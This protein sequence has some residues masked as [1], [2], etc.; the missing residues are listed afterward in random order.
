MSIIVCLFVAV[1]SAR[2][3]DK[4]AVR[5]IQEYFANYNPETL[6]LK[7][8][9]LE[10]KRGNIVI[11]R[12][13]ITIYTNKNFGSQVFTPELVDNIYSGLKEALPSS[14]KKYN[15][16]IIANHRR[17]EYLVPNIY[18]KKKAVD[19]TRLWN[20][21]DYAGHAWVRNVSRPYAIA[22]GLDGR[23]IALW[24]SHGRVYS[25]DKNLWQWQRP[26]LFCTTEDLFT[27]SI[28]VPF[29]MPMLE[30]AG[31][32][33]YTPR[34]RSWQRHSVVVDNDATTGSSQYVEE[35]EGN[36]AW[37][38]SQYAGFAPRDTFYV[39]G[40]NPFSEGTVRVTACVSA[41]KGATA[42]AKWL[43]DI[44]EDG[45]YGVYV[46]YQTL[47][48]S[49]PD[50]R[51][52]VLHSGG[53]TNFHVNQ[54]MGGGTWVYLGSFYFK[55]GIHENQSVVLSNE[56]AYGGVVTADAVR[57]GGGMGIVARGDSLKV[58]NLPR[59]LE[60]AR[61][62]LQYSGFPYKVY[63]PS[64]GERDYNDD[65][66]SR[67]RAVN[68][69]VG[70]S[71]YCPDSAGLRVPIEMTFGFHSDA[72]I[73]EED[74]VIGSLGVVTTDY[75]D[76]TLPTGVSRYISRDFI[77]Y[78]LNCVQRDI[79]E[80]YGFR[81]SCRGIL[82]KSYSESRIPYVP[83]MIFESLS[84]QNFIDMAYGHDPNFKFVIARA[85][86]KALLKHLAYVHGRDYIVQPLPVKDFSIDFGDE[87]NTLRLAWMPVEDPLEPTAVAKKYILYTK[88][89]DNEYDNGRVVES[90]AIVFPVLPDVQ[91][92]FKVA[93]LNEGGESFPSEELS[94]CISKVEKGRVVVVNGFHRLSGPAVVNSNSLAGFD[95]DADPG[96]PYMRTP[97]YCGRQLD[98]ERI[99]T[100]FEDGLGLSGCELEG[101][102]VAGNT[103]N[104][105][106]IHGKAL[107]ANEYSY[108]SC[109]SEAVMNDYV[110]LGKYDAVDLILGCEKQGGKGSVLGYNR[111]YKTFPAELQNKITSYC[112][113]GGRIFVSGAYIASDMARN[114]SDRAFIRNILKFD[115]GGYVADMSENSIFGSNLTFEVN[116]GISEKC[117]AVTRPDI[118]APVGNSFV[119]FVFDKC[120]ESAGVAF[121]DN[122]RVLTTSFPF[123]TILQDNFRAEIMGA[124]MR[125]LMN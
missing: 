119:A 96:V 99:N 6:R 11:G 30:N 3:D 59:F 4:Q 123:E 90:N 35:H 114:D 36:A 68:H 82:D 105:P 15:I 73:S 93:A 106:Y 91:Y 31:A 17:I 115:Y 85:V 56:S 45:E 121:A 44:P 5:A 111:A 83:S 110:Q 63:S 2:N 20:G 57:F 13:K 89:N 100:G 19:D 84:H 94:A 58:S 66:N 32:L 18:R 104:Y 1:V 37:S 75:E 81:W 49:V 23:H 108:V 26:S 72:G 22:S 120:R 76:G 54:Q 55:K 38:V 21:R 116:R 51:Y 67:S 25:A 40:E 77:S 88:I 86:Y 125:F 24:Q 28:V 7:N 74:E 109:S 41:E 112:E 14:Y 122:Y 107:V 27:Q 64:E 102:L 113:A 42:L 29:L 39:D 101:M 8:C 9:G 95:I 62:A 65:I 80:T 10:R 92:S 117:Y 124:V 71:V 69:L 47:E 60:G 33:V 34:E 16:E 52:S 48:G 97:E 46:S 79:G 12:K 53:V 43:P 70:G 50:A 87:A 118:L 98:F 61:Y 78:I 103:F